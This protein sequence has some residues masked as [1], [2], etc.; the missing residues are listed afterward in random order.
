MNQSCAGIQDQDGSYFK[1]KS[2][3]AEIDDLENDS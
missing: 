1:R 2:E 3:G